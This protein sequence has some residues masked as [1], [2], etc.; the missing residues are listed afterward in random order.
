M[1]F[2][3]TGI[4]DISDKNYTLELLI[5]ADDITTVKKFLGGQKVIII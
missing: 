1:F 3:L 2:R 4:K 5:E